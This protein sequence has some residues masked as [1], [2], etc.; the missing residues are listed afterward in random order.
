MAPMACAHSSVVSTPGNPLKTC[1]HCKHV[2]YCNQNCQK[3]HY[4]V[5]KANCRLTHGAHIA[6]TKECDLGDNLE[7]LE[8]K[9]RAGGPNITIGPG[10][11]VK[12]VYAPTPE[13]PEGHVCVVPYIML[14][15]FDL[16]AWDEAAELTGG[17]RERRR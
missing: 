12:K 17:E 4:K 3:A 8:F 11:Y 6:K 15:K 10:S 5:H 2:Y 9:R 13:I 7:H 14:K 16:K 1:S